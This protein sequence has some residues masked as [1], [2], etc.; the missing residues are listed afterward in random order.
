MVEELVRHI[1][2]QRP[3]KLT[4]CNAKATP[5]SGGKMIT[6]AESLGFDLAISTAL[7]NEGVKNHTVK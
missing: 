4:F 7:V 1:A 2:P 3:R 5:V 6:H